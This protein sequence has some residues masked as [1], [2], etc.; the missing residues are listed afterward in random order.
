M[1]SRN[2]I[3]IVLVVIAI[4]IMAYLLLRGN[5]PKYDWNT[6]YYKASSQPYGTDL[7]YKLLDKTRGVK[8][9]TAYTLNQLDSATSGTTLFYCLS[10][11]ESDSTACLKI[12]DY[13]EKGNNLV[14]ATDDAPLEMMRNFIPLGVYF[15]GYSLKRDSLTALSFNSELTPDSN[16]IDLVYRKYND[17]IGY[18]WGYYSKPYFNDTLHSYGFEAYAYFPDSSVCAF[19]INHGKGKILIHANPILFT[20]FYFARNEGYVHTSNMLRYFQKGKVF[21]YEYGYNPDESYGSDK[22]S[23]N[24]LRFLFKHKSLKTAWYLL[25]ISILLYIIFRSKRRQRI[26]PILPTIKNTEIEFIKTSALLYYKAR[27]HHH[28]AKEMYTVFLAEIRSRY[29]IATDSTEQEM[30]QNLSQKS[31]IDTQSITK[32]FSQFKYVMMPNVSTN[33]DL[34][35]LHALIENYHKLKK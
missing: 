20:N 30:I 22:H 34:I 27:G 12:L 24:P 32:I 25:L 13:V 17:T 14:I 19:V 5:G 16:S 29:N 18:T 23:N 21:W 6:N 15:N 9:I 1:K 26:I 8:P 7:F 10:S 35:E 3:G 4:V 11:F 2:N 31:G 28:I 33:E